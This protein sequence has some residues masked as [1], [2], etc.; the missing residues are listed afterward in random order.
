VVCARVL[1]V[2]CT[3]PRSMCS[4]LVTLPP[5][6]LSPSSF[7]RYLQEMESRGIQLHPY[8]DA[9]V[10]VCLM[11]LCGCVVVQRETDYQLLPKVA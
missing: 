1:R 8:I 3:R 6:T 4:Y 7:H 11:E 10:S 2:S 9:E 5:M